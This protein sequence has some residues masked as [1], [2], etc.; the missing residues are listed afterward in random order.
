LVDGAAGEVPPIE[1]IRQTRSLPALQ[2]LV[3]LYAAQFLPGYGGVPRELLKVVFERTKVGEQGPFVV[4]GFRS[5]RLLAG[6][7]LYRPFL[8]GQHKSGSSRDAG[9]DDAFWPA[10]HALE[11]LGLVEE[12][13]HAARR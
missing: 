3:E 7:A 2:L 4:W 11:N 8:T 9:V 6:L 10:V 5:K 1:L 12:V 13:R